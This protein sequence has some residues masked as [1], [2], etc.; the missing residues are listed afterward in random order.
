MASTNDLTTQEGVDTL[1]SVYEYSVD[2]VGEDP[3]AGDLWLDTANFCVARR[4]A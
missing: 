1:K 2:V 4:R 3:D